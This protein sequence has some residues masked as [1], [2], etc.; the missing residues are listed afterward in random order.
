MTEWTELKTLQDVA[1]AQADGWEIEARAFGNIQWQSWGGRAW[2]YDLIYRGRP[3]QPK[4][5]EV[6]MLCWK[7]NGRLDWLEEGTHVAHPSW[8]RVPAEDKTI[9]VPE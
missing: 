3:K 5:E 9:E 1:K 7:V 4:M 2:K 6:K 8:V